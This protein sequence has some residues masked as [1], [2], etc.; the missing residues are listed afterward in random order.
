MRKVAHGA[1]KNAH[2]RGASGGGRIYSV[3]R[4]EVAV[5]LI[6]K[7]SLM[8]V[9][10]QTEFVELAKTT[11]R[12][13]SIYLPT[14]RADVSAHDNQLRFKALLHTASQRLQETGLSEHDS[15]RFLESAHLL[16]DK[17]LFWQ[18]LKRTLVV[19]VSEHDFRVFH[20]PL[21]CEELCIVGNRFHIAPLLQMLN[22]DAPY[23]LLAVSQNH[24]RL[25]RGAR[26]N[27]KE[28]HVPELP[29]NRQVSLNYD[30]REGFYQT[31]SGEPKLRGKE[32]V[33]FTGQGGE[34]DVAKDEISAYFRLIDAAV[35]NYLREQTEPLIFVGVDYL[36]PLYHRHNHYPFLASA[37]IAGNPEL[38]SVA[39][40]RER[41]WPIMESLIRERQE[42]AIGRY[43]ELIGQG[44][45]SNRMERILD[46]AE[47]GMVETL[48]ICPTVR[49]WGTFD[50]L[51]QTLHLDSGPVP[52]N[53]ELVNLAVCLVLK[54]RGKV[55][56]IASGNIPGGGAL[57][58][59]FRF[60]PQ[61]AIA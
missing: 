20:L 22:E 15:G 45:S 39:E 54:H 8:T 37:H 31:H 26:E 60:M 44:R 17:L 32:G 46:A 4:F 49:R 48:F 11:G 51:A 21:E 57:A 23:Y 9:I 2:L 7:V 19:F 42:T 41:A 56:S 25:L 58:A 27:I 5:W 38:F 10:N 50:P 34:A 16:F 30:P 36:F 55:E 3:L 18:T 33:V 53:E 14:Y 1:H 40:L 28:V 43:W 12:S 52:G 13:V 6:I 24:V 35:S 29:S 59:A 47:N 61:P